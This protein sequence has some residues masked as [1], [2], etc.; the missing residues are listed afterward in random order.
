MATLDSDP[1]TATFA[2]RMTGTLDW[3]Q[4]IGMLEGVTRD[5]LT[6]I[7][8]DTN[9]EESDDSDNPDSELVRYEF[10]EFIIRIAIAKNENDR[11]KFFDKFVRLNVS[12]QGSPKL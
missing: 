5:Q 1:E 4:H 9:I 12:L 8:Y 2:A 11:Q 10:M 6:Q 7:W 3:M